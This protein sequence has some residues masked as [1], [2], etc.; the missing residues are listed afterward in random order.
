MER[1][2][3][4]DLIQIAEFLVWILRR[5]GM[6]CREERFAYLV[7]LYLSFSTL[8]CSQTVLFCGIRKSLNCQSN[9]AMKH[10]VK[11]AVVYWRLQTFTKHILHYWPGWLSAISYHRNG[12]N[13]NWQIYH[14]K[15][16]T[17]L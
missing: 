17:S 1:L 16:F 11:I 9:F 2:Y 13:I 14:L 7:L 12:E 10:L 4:Y 5:E 15:K 8:M 3:V 6:E